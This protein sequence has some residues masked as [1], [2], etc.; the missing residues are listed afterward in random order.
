M[1]QNPN[2]WVG[3]DSESFGPT[4]RSAAIGDW[5]QQGGGIGGGVNQ[6]DFSPGQQGKTILPL[7]ERTSLVFFCSSHIDHQRSG[8]FCSG[9][10][11][12]GLFCSVLFCSVLFCSVLFSSVLF[13]S[14]L[15]LGS[16]AVLGTKSGWWYLC[17]LGLTGRPQTAGGS[18]SCS[19]I[20]HI[21]SPP[22]R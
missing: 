14:L 12:S 5:G 6:T 1:K 16:G 4:R 15:V 22:K 2:A 8:L 10:F 11:C 21:G 17:K 18:C 9:L 3:Y 19:P 13:C 20:H 7:H